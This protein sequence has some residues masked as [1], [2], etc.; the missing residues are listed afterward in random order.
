MS[1]SPFLTAYWA[2]LLN[3]TYQVP[4]ELLAPHLP[5]GLELDVQKGQA[6]I[7]LVA[8][9]FLDTR[10]K[11]IK[12]PSHVNFPEI[13]LRYYV[14]YR[15]K[16][17]VVFLKEFVPKFCIALV[18]RRIY[19]EP[20]EAIGMNVLTEKTAKDIKITHNLSYK[21]FQHRISIQ[22][23]NTFNLPA[24]DSVAHYFKEHELGFGVNHQGQSLSYTVEHP[25][26]QV[27]EG[28]EIDLKLDFGQL[29]GA[30]WAFLNESKAYFSCLAKGSSIKVFPAK[31]LSI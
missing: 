28:L 11:G 26:W 24:D 4:P 17:G 27:Y 20:Y 23:N 1:S 22:A 8:F 9:E 7:S 19:N 13:N 21:G 16:R 2:N 31:E 12:I 3:I 25:K 30:K 29:Y 14:K 15:G 18:A 10:V 5:L 6:F